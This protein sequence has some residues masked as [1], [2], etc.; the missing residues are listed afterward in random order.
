MNKLQ[1]FSLVTIIAASAVFFAAACGGAKTENAAATEKPDVVV[2][3]F[4]QPLKITVSK[5]G[6][7]PKSLGV[8]KGQAVRL[9]FIRTDE[10]NCGDEIVFPKQNIRKK[11]PLNETVPVEFTPAESGEVGFT[12]GMDMLRGKILVQ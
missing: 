10:E 9:A 5:N 1:K 6:F 7:E 2:E 11:L 4:D 8:K 3:S 12:C